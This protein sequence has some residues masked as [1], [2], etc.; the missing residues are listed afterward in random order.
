M[1][2]NLPL[3][4]MQRALAVHELLQPDPAP[5]ICAQRYDRLYPRPREQIQSVFLICAFSNA[6]ARE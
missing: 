4:V 2:M 1:H 3:D 5:I 6:V